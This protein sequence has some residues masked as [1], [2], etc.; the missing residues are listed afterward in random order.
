MRRADGLLEEGQE[1]RDGGARYVVVH[2]DH[3]ANPQ[4]FGHAWAKLL[5]G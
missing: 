3:P 1:L 4:S 5:T 2:V